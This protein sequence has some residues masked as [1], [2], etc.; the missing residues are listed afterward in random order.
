[1]GTQVKERGGMLSVTWMT[2][3]EN[4]PEHRDYRKCLIPLLLLV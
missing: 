2:M 1:V 4:T 3:V